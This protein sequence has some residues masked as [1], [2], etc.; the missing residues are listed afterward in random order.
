MREGFADIFRGRIDP[1]DIAQQ[2]GESEFVYWK[3]AYIEAL[4]MGVAPEE[5][6]AGLNKLQKGFDLKKT[7][8]QLRT[9]HTPYLESGKPKDRM[10]ND[11]YKLY[12]PKKN[13]CWNCR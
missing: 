6:F 5:L 9:E 8:T 4:N 7:R 3:F 2:T 12:F 13:Y 1:N 11:R 10:T